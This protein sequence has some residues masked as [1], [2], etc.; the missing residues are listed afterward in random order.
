MIVLM[1]I[2]LTLGFEGGYATPANG[3]EDIS[4]G[5]IFS[6]SSIHRAGAL[7]MR[8]GV[9]GMSNRGE[10]SG[11]SLSTYGLG[12]WMFKRSWRFSPEIF[13]G[14]D[15][16]RRTLGQAAESGYAVTYGAGMLVNFRYD[17]LYLYPKVFYEG[18]TD[19]RD[20]G[21]FVGIMLGVAYEF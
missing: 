5:I 13:I 8:L 17:V 10:H 15:Y 19:F 6:M 18:M 4:S 16:V 11:Y 12:A 9:H 2:S 14:V 21:G 3:F 20:S 7:D 1:L